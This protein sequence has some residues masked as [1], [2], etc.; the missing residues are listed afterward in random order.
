MCD[1]L[2]I[3]DIDNDFSCRMEEAVIHGEL[4]QHDSRGTTSS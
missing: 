3:D 1:D 4:D 2:S